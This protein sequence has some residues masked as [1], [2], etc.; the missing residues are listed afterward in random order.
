MSELR[1]ARSQP[2]SWRS[3]GRGAVLGVMTAAALAAAL[4]MAP[5]AE[6]TT[7]SPESAPAS[8]ATAQGG[9]PQS[10]NP[11]GLGRPHTVTWDKHSL[12][13]DGQRL[14]LWSA[15][16]HY[17]RLPSP[18]LW[19][20]EL[21]KMKA[22]GHNAV[23]LYFNWD[24]H[25]PK[26]GVYDFNG[27]RDINKLLQMAAEQGIYVLA[28]PG[29]YINAETDGGGL[30]SWVLADNPLRTDADCT[31]ACPNYGNYL[32][33]AKAW[34]H[35]VDQILVKN[36]LTNGTGPIILYQVENELQETTANQARYQEALAAQ[37]RADGISVPIYNNDAGLNGLWVP[38]AAGTKSTTPARWND[39]YGFDDYPQGFSCANPTQWSPAPDREA[40]FRSYDTTTPI[41]SPEF[42]G[43]SVDFG[44]FGFDA[45]RELTNS[46]FERVFE[47]TNFANGMTMENNYMTAGGTS[48]GGLINGIIGYTSYDYGSMIT[49]GR[50]LTSKYY[51]Q[52]QIGYFLR[53][54]APLTNTD[55][56]PEPAAVNVSPAPGTSCV[57]GKAGNP[58][59]PDCS[60]IRVYHRANAETGTHFYFT[61]HS[62]S[63]SMTDS[64]FNFPI[65]TSDG[66][67]TIPRK[68]ALQLNGRDMK[69]VVADWD[70]DTS[71]SPHH[72]V[73]STSNIMTA[74]SIG[75]RDVVSLW[76]PTGQSGETVLRYSDRPTVTTL[77]GT[78]PTITWEAASVGG[79]LR[80]DYGHSGTSIVR[81]SGGGSAQPLLLILT[82]D[83][84]SKELWSQT[85][86]SGPVLEQGPELVRTA[87]VTGRTLA[88]TGDTTHPTKLRVWAPSGVRTVTWNGTPL[89]VAPRA[90]GSL[91]SAEELPGPAPMTLPALTDWTHQKESPEAE[92]A[93]DDTSWAKADHQVTNNPT[94]PPAGQ[95]VLYSDD[96]G[97]HH[98][99][100]W[101]RGHFTPSAA[102]TSISIRSVTGGPGLTMA[103]LNGTYLTP[104]STAN[105]TTTY[106]VPSGVV[107]TGVDNV[108]SVQAL[109]AGHDQYIHYRG[110]LIAGP[111]DP[112]GLSSVTTEPSTPIAWKIQGNEGGENLTDTVR[113][114]MN[115]GGLYGERAGW[116]LPGYPADRWAPNTLPAENSTPG[117]TWYRTTFSLNEPRDVDASIGLNIADAPASAPYTAVIY[118]NGWNIGTYRTIGV[119]HTFVL[120][121]GILQ[122][123]I[124]NSGKNTL[125]IAVLHSSTAVGGLG[126]V[127][128]TASDSSNLGVV[129]GGVP[130]MDVTT[131]RYQPPIVTAVDEK[132]T[133]N[134]FT[135]T[136]A[137]VAEPADALG[138]ALAA[139]I[140]WGDGS[141]TPGTV[142]G[143]KGHYTVSGQHAFP[144]RGRHAIT[145][146]I[147]DRA[148]TLPLGTDTGSVIVLKR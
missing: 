16:F 17:W 140:N 114:V 143:S 135:G 23:Q 124:R 110:V 85:T 45:C 107:K 7:S 100:V 44:N 92:S 2:T 9:A 11:L 57:N 79:D 119:Q 102:L 18:S 128:L 90:D 78:A 40:D 89:S 96:Y 41:F 64:T 104:A 82:D 80:L 65:T 133:G 98:G 142:T 49:E 55:P 69:T 84:T 4:V 1:P 62:D 131:P 25:S 147:L 5:L 113:G 97:F 39:L 21:Q 61:R 109:N 47:Q 54:V 121:N 8:V 35:A 19:E 14:F 111:A 38:S 126:A 63:R 30:P 136:V 34:L 66:T 13:I 27:V 117:T 134:Q 42:Q 148:S 43:G 32:S 83:T 103:W 53:S 116:S 106:T 46:Q 24:Y 95:P 6:A 33:Q 108:L 93:F 145:V 141:R 88:L 146:T 132:V 60:S 118:L 74:D 3:I 68:G 139:T 137:T 51:A 71:V 77:E 48:W 70:L 76:A 127:R 12:K 50:Q 73:Y 10:S 87:V 26:Q 129:N 115:T 138:T 36:Q 120:P 29:P 52:K 81:I 144:K 130:V 123:G 112:R 22:S 28:R 125:A 101:Y 37:V 58:V 99:T 59:L 86:P 105:G 56:R 72:L 31:V 15:E 122:T 67:Y 94:P 91:N 75:G 20:D